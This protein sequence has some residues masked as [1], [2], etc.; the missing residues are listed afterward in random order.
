MDSTR[1]RES[2][3]G[4]ESETGNDMRSMSRSVRRGRCGIAEDLGLKKE[5][6]GTGCQCRILGSVVEGIRSD[7]RMWNDS[8]DALWIVVVERLV[9]FQPGLLR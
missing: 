4:T 2:P 9:V 7:E 3:L 6:D 8:V 5:R 1:R